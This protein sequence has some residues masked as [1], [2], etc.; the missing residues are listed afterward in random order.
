MTTNAPAGFSR[1]E[2]GISA[3]PAENVYT[4][5]VNQVSAPL[6]FRVRVE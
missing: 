5:P 1:H 2:G 3:T 4:C 6:F